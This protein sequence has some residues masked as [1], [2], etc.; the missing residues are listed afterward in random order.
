MVAGNADASS[1]DQIVADAKSE[2]TCEGA[3]SKLDKNGFL[4]KACE[5]YL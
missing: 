3:F 4:T 2:F 5:T 1:R